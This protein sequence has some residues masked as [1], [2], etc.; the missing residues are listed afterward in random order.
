MIDHSD[1]HNE[2]L[3]AAVDNDVAQQTGDQIPDL[4][5]QD[6]ADF[7][8]QGTE[9]LLQGKATDAVPFLERAHNM[10]PQDVDAGIN[11]SGAYILT[12]KFK[13]A[14]SILEPLS[15]QVPDNAMIWT[16]L[17]AAT[18]GN[19][20][21]ANDEEQRRAISAFERALAIDPVATSVA[22]NIGL[23]YRDRR[24]DDKAIEWFQKAVKHD[25]HDQDARS[26]LRK[27][28]MYQE[29]ESGE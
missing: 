16:N 20:V 21:L 26:L 25:P 6:F 1:M 5:E 17:G 8:R 7:Y 4:G 12:K 2:N 28:T 27:L 9:L 18:L 11:L 19:P 10:R 15:E 23:I 3:E 22:Y 14:R 29:Q 24:E 13:R